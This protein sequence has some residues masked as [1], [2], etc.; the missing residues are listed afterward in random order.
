VA[1]SAAAGASDAS[2]P[3]DPKILAWSH[4]YLGRIHDREGN[5]DLALS[6]YRAALAVE[7]APD[8]ARLAAQRGVEAE[9]RV[10]PNS[11]PQVR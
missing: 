1:A 7:G 8:A 4:I 2:G 11:Q 10:S 9:T 6:E 5:R 3:A